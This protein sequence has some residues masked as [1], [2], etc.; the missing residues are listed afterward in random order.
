MYFFNNNFEHAHT[1]HV[2]FRKNKP[3]P[4]LIIEKTIL[5]F[6][7]HNNFTNRSCF[8]S[9]GCNILSKVTKLIRWIP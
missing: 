4:F 1:N 6:Q 9:E 5:I 8:D 7:N 3:I 2:V